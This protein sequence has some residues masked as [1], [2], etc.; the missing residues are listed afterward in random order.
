MSMY[1]NDD[2]D[3]KKK[4]MIIIIIIMI[5][6]LLSLMIIIMSRARPR[7]RL[8]PRLSEASSRV[9]RTSF[10]LTASSWGRERERDITIN[11][12]SSIIISSSSSIGI[13][14]NY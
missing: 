6:L 11:I 13:I 5:L 10:S 9:R 2:D 7:D 12:I 14:K 8:G 4:I 3:D 1:N